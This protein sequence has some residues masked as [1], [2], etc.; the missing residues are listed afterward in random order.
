MVVLGGRVLYYKRGTP[1]PH[2][3]E[4][5]GTPHFFE[6]FDLKNGSSQDHNLALTVLCAE[7]NR[8][9]IMWSCEL[10]VVYKLQLRIPH[11]VKGGCFTH[12][13]FGG[14][15]VLCIKPTSSLPVT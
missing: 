12:V 4:D 5:G 13:S 10:T 8:Q 14:A 3:S 6:S 1:V 2:P 11:T 9:R 7:F 15:S